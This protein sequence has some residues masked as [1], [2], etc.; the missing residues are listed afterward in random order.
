MRR[1][2]PEIYWMALTTDSWT[3]ADR[4]RAVAPACVLPA[5]PRRCSAESSAIRCV[6]SRLMPVAE[7]YRGARRRPLSTTA[8]TP[9]MVMELSAIGVASTT[10]RCWFR[11]RGL[12]G[13]VNNECSGQ[14]TLAQKNDQGKRHALIANSAPHTLSWLSL[15]VSQQTCCE[16]TFTTAC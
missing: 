7:S 16:S 9:S 14:Y 8:V 6:T 2:G 3:L 4:V 1:A 11:P 15:V 13:Y 10:R 5:R 12:R